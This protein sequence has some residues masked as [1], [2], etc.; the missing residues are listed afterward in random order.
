MKRKLLIGTIVVF[1]IA[2]AIV[3][4]M[5]TAGALIAVWI[6]LVFMVRKKK[7]N[8]FHDQME[9]K[10]AERRLKMLKAFLLVAGISFAVF[11]VGVIVHNALYGLSE[12]EEPVS[13]I[14]AISALWVF[15]IATVGGLVIFL[16]GRRKQHKGIPI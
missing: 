10:I 6:Y 3:M 13:F 1:G 7:T 15:I 5:L 11:I 4:A 8:L 12:I 2:A 16:K 14:I 9:P